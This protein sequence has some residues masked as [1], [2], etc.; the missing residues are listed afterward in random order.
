[1]V[2]LS[3]AQQYGVRYGIMGNLVWQ[4]VGH[5]HPDLEP[6]GFCV[7]IGY[8][9]GERNLAAVS[10]GHCQ[11]YWDAEYHLQQDYDDQHSTNPHWRG[12]SHSHSQRSLY[13][14]LG[15]H[16]N[17]DGLLQRHG[18]LY[19]N[20]HWH[21]HLSHLVDGFVHSHGLYNGH[22]HAELLAVLY[23]FAVRKP[24]WDAQSH[25]VGHGL[26]FAEWYEVWNFV[27]HIH[28]LSHLH[29]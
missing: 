4:R 21:W 8:Q 29:G 23:W 27:S 13:G 11:Q 12:N 19:S 14:H 24:H 10:V 20:P 26:C 22:G 5:D 25:G 2:F 18:D 9:Y 6:H 1:M 16:A 3:L 28:S 7:G 15:N 17:L